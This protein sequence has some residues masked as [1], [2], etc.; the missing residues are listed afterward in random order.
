MNFRRQ[1]SASYTKQG[2]ILWIEADP[3]GSLEAYRQA[4]ALNQRL[5]EELPDDLEIRFE[6]A[7]SYQNVGYVLGAFVGF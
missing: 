2:D 6:L 4:L 1:L 5:A 7:M 3:A